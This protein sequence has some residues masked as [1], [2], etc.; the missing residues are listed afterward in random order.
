MSFSTGFRVS[1]Y[2]QDGADPEAAASA[3]KIFPMNAHCTP[4]I[5]AHALPCVAAACD[6]VEAEV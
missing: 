2:N 4:D 6:A 1:G 5:M 3:L